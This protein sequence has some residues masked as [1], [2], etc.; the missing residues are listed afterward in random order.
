M[1][2]LLEGV[3]QAFFVEA[4]DVEDRSCCLCNDC[5]QVVVTGCVLE[6]DLS[7][8]STLIFDDVTTAL[9]LDGN[10][11]IEDEELSTL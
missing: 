1:A 4:K 10:A 11:V 3:V 9:V 8:D 6:H 5:W 2:L 7:H